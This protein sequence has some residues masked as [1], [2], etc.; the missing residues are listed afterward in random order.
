MDGSFDERETTPVLRTREGLS[1]QLSIRDYVTVN[2]HPGKRPLIQCAQGRST[3]P[4]IEVVSV[5]PL[6]GEGK[7]VHSCATLVPED[8]GS[9]LGL[10]RMWN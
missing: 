1:I 3:H 9:G 4:N 8:T 7:T 5:G 6:E 2:L 10:R